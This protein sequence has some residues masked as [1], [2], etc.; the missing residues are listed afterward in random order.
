MKLNQVISIEQTVKSKCN[1][2]KSENYKI[3][4]KPGLF[5]GYIKRYR[6]KSE[7]GESFPDEKAKVQVTAKELLDSEAA[8]LESLFNIEATKDFANCLAKADIVVDGKVLVKDAPVTYLLY[9]SKEL[10]DL[11]TF[12]SAIPV[13]T[14]DEEWKVD[15]Q[16]GLARTE[17]TQTVKTKKIQKP[18]VLYPATDKHPAQT[19]LITEDEVV[20]SWDH[21]KF[22]GAF[23]PAQ[24]KALLAKIQKLSDAV[25]VAREEANTATAD[26]V[27]AGTTLVDWLFR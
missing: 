3:A 9:L 5:N 7:D 2:V 6:A 1:S 20:G 15:E 25:K 10:T 16:T 24:K 13:L 8:L 14:E 23:Q 17:P 11:D 19:Q 22:S 4:Q 21:V 27:N 26:S 18:I 12:V